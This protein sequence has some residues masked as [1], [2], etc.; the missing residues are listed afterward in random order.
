M[1]AHLG[2]RQAYISQQLSVLREAG[3]IQDR[4]D[5]WNIFYRA[6]D[7]RIY[8]V[9]STMRQ[10]TGQELPEVMKPEVVCTCPKCSTQDG[11]GSK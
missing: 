7:E 2:L 6:A 5:G 1:E 8:D 11:V 3:L 9:L 4:R 10:I